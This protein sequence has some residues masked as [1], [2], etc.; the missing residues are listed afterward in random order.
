MQQFF[1]HFANAALSGCLSAVLLAC[2]QAS[3]TSN[4]P[5]NTKKDTP[6][7]SQQVSIRVGELGPELLK[8][9]SNLVKVQ[10][11]PAGVD[12]YE[13]DWERPRGTIRIEHGQY[14]FVIEDVLGVS[15]IQD[16]GPLKDE[17]LFIVDIKSG[18]SVPSPSLI[19]HDEAR[20]KTYAILQR[21]LD[22]GW[23][24]IVRRH[25]PR[26]KGK[27]RFDYA[28]TGTNSIIGLDPYYVPTFQEWMGIDSMTYWLF[29][30]DHQYLSVYFTRERTLTDPTKP[31]AYLLSFGIKSDI[32][33]ARAEV[34]PNERANWKIKL[35]AE[36]Q[37]SA[38]DRKKKEAELRAKGIKIDETYEDPPVPD[39]K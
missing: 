12:F 15:A 36:I 20:L 10:H 11:Q 25:Q 21:I 26:L 33:E 17:G 34:G 7:M 18:M 23:R 37:A 16:L 4:T 24:P 14:S 31:G 9:Y 6:A 38:E 8:R 3:S 39:L 29:Y 35:P 28:M 13:I 2:G 19:P 1:K 22:A 27:V 5:P 32:E 30:A